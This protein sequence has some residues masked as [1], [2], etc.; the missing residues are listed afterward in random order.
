MSYWSERQSP[1]FGAPDQRS[2]AIDCTPH[3]WRSANLSMQPVSR[4]ISGRRLSCFRQRSRGPISTGRAARK[5]NVLRHRGG[6]EI[7]VGH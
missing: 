1:V 5:G 3:R 6:V 2:A 7:P 4:T